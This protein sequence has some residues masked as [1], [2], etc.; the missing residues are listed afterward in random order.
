MNLYQKFK[1]ECKDW[2]FPVFVLAL[3]IAPIAPV[4]IYWALKP[5]P[6]EPL[7]P[8]DKELE[9]KETKRLEKKA[10]EDREKEYDRENA[11]RFE[12]ERLK[13]HAYC[14]QEKMRFCKEMIDNNAKYPSWNY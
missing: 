2:A 14:Y 3:F 10:D 7:P 5:K 6:P 1:K 11:K 8:T 13:L 4:W 12:Q 9:I